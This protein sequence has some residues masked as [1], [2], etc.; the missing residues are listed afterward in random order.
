[1][2]VTPYK[3]FSRIGVIV[4]LPF[5]L[6]ACA[7][8]D[9][10]KPTAPPITLNAPP[11][12]VIEG[13]CEITGELEEWL[14][15][16]T[17]T[18]QDFQARLDEAAAKNAPDVHDD[19][20]YLVALRDT[21]ANTTTP[22]CGVTVQE[23]LITSMSGAVAALQGYYNGTLTSDLATALT[24]PQQGLN[25]AQGLQNELITR[26]RNQYQIENNLTPTPTV[27]S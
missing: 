8:N 19:T 4:L 16:T 21:V 5:C 3:S 6:A 13:N 14:Q 24:E 23:V 22:D 7:I 9:T 12:T 25:Q 1:M 10:A 18:R 11:I 27:A 2:Q 15:V 20:L 26:M 17:R